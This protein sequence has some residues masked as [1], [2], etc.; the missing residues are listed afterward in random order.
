M[1]ERNFYKHPVNKKSFAS[2]LRAKAAGRYITR[3]GGKYRP[4][5]PASLRAARVRAAKLARVGAV[6]QAVAKQR[7]E[8]AKARVS[9]I[10][11]GTGRVVQRA[12]RGKSSSKGKSASSGGRHDG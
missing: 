1:T 2:V 7:N 5:K 3:E 10:K 9:R 4:M 8:R 11:A 6:K 12:L